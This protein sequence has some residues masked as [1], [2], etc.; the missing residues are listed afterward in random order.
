MMKNIADLQEELCYV[1]RREAPKHRDQFSY[2]LDN[3][4]SDPALHPPLAQ[5]SG[6][7]NIEHLSSSRPIPTVNNRFQST[8]EHVNSY[9]PGAKPY[10]QYA[11]G[12]FRPSGD[13]DTFD[14][15]Y[16]SQTSLHD[17][18][19]NT[20]QS[21]YRGE[22]GQVYPN[23]FQ[24]SG[25]NPVGP[26][27]HRQNYNRP[28]ESVNS[29]QSYIAENGYGRD[30]FGQFNGYD[31]TGVRFNDKSQQPWHG[32]QEPVSEYEHKRGYQGGSSSF[33]N[34]L[35]VRP[36]NPKYQDWFT[37]KTHFESVA[38]E[39]GWTPQV[40]CLKLL[41]AL[42]GTMTG[43]TTG[44]STL[45]YPMLINRIDSIQGICNSR[46]D[47][48]IKLDYCR[49]GSEETVPMYGERVRQLVERAHP[50]M[51]PGEKNHC[52]I[53]TFVRGL[54]SKYDF[55]MK[56]KM[57]VF[58]SLTEAVEHGGRLYNI[59]QEE[60]RR[61][62]DKRPIYSRKVQNEGICE[63]SGEYNED[64]QQYGISEM[65]LRKVTDSVTTKL[66]NDFT[67][68]QKSE[69]KSN[70]KSNVYH[71]DKR[72]ELSDQGSSQ[73]TDDPER[74]SSCYICGE[75]DHWA[76]RCPQRKSNHD[77][78]SRSVTAEPLN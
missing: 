4:V 24:Q 57:Q 8:S 37:Y 59:I 62:Q 53:R 71:Q 12:Q 5:S 74:K 65:M 46:E 2:N 55:R 34:N 68:T 17:I 78:A 38:K 9:H 75:Y 41:G 20:V 42:E 35:K 47:A 21:P 27:L 72:N 44:M 7:A 23:R 56:M 39:A 51:S 32:G 22:S 52:A 10:S 19:C 16:G 54:P 3:Q 58:K 14:T 48:E 50:A 11:Q 15:R 63:S 30:D 26:N 73:R 28:H 60:H 33:M 45:S 66:K 67:M 70:G 36:F 49:L 13:I 76:N 69:G 64:D 61:E 43:I 25:Y 6:H 40:K 18:H 1:R 29:T 77:Q 31:N